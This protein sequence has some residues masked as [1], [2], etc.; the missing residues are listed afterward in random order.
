MRKILP[1]ILIYEG[2]S[3][4]LALLFMM[5]S[6]SVRFTMAFLIFLALGFT[7][8]GIVLLIAN[9]KYKV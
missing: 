7:G 4:F 2:I 3:A 1:I 6:P 5:P 8:S 9:K